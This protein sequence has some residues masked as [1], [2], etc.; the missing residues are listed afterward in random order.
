MGRTRLASLPCP[1]RPF[2][3]LAEAHL[4]QPVLVPEGSLTPRSA[5]PHW[6]LLG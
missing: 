6:A 4:L 5:R 1:K 2:P 3:F